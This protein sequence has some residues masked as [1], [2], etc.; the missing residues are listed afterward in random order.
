MTK[1][2]RSRLK[3]AREA[4]GVSLEFVAVKVDRSRQTIWN[5]ENGEG[6]PT[7]TNL[8]NLAIALNQ[9]MSF[10]YEITQEEAAQ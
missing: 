1:F 7:A 9:P 8:L 3:Q 10:F 4:A 2:S 5:W 6:E